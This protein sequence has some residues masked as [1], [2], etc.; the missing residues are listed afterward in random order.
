MHAAYVSAQTAPQD[1]AEALEWR[2]SVYAWF[3]QFRSTVRA[4]LPNSS[5]VTVETDPGSY[6]RNL[7][8]AFMGSVEAR[9][10]RWSF[11]ADGVYVDFSRGNSDITSVRTPGGDVHLPVAASAH[12]DLNGFIGTFA[13]GYTVSKTPA[14]TVDAVAG[15]RYMRIKANVDAA[16]TAPVPGLPPQFA[17]E[18]TRDFW[19]GVVGVRGRVNAGDAWFV[20]FHFDVG[21]GSSQ[22]TWQAFAGIGYRFAW[23]DA[24]LGYRH[25]QYEFDRDRPISDLQFSGPLAGV[26]LRF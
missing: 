6:L 22:V 13:A 23:G 4:T 26:A 3:P 17:L 5:T 21:T 16:L 11:I 25:L 9:R 7:E 19:D 12:A 20:P 8:V 15:A 10:G 1:N 18:R 14:T 24:V 2:A